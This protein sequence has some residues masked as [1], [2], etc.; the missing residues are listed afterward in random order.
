M[1]PE[2]IEM[3]EGLRID[4]RLRVRGFP[5]RWQ[6]EITV[7]DPPNRFVDEQ[8]R[9]PYRVWRHEHQF[10]DSNGGTWCGDLVRYAAPGGIFR[11]WIERLWV[12]RDVAKI[13]EYRRR[14]LNERLGLQATG[15]LTSKMEPR[16]GTL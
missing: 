3:R 14:A 15:N 16:S 4:Y 7:W 12:N 8:R 5:M 9:G 1:T 13:F 10:Q 11:S 2:P 6:S